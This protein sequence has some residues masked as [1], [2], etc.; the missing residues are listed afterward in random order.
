MEPN[1][2]TTRFEFEKNGKKAWF[3]C[4][5]EMTIGSLYDIAMELRSWAMS[6]MKELE[7]KESPKEDSECES[8]E[9][10]KDEE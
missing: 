1:H 8:C 3:I 10:V 9:E 7:E 5:S 4:D 2:A 6:K